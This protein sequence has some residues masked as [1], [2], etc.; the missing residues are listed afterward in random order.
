MSLKSSFSHFRL[1]FYDLNNENP[2]LN[3]GDCSIW[4]PRSKPQSS[5]ALTNENNSFEADSVTQI[6][7]S[8]LE[9]LE[10]GVNQ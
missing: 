1:K 2:R 3:D 8:A 7:G 5:T 6:R 10:G 9:I 4:E